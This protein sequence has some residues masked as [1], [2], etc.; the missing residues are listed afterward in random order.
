MKK[1]SIS[2]FLIFSFIIAH[3]QWLLTGN[4]GTNSL[5]NFVGTIDGQ[6]LIFR[7]GNSERLRISLN[8]RLL[9]T[10]STSNLFI[11]SAAGKSCGQ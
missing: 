7:T 4:S 5:T 8:G 2:M 10:G 9:T 11:G 6:E 3:S 1:C